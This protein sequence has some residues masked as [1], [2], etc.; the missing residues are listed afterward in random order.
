MQ[1]KPAIG[2]LDRRRQPRADVADEIQELAGPYPGLFDY[3]WPLMRLGVHALAL[4]RLD[5]ETVSAAAEALRH[6]LPES[7]KSTLYNISLNWRRSAAVSFGI[8]FLI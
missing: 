1:N 8:S 2:A 5:L 6:D 4:D 7:N 3:L